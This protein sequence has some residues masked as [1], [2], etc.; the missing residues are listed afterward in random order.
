MA[1]GNMK[2]NLDDALVEPFLSALD[3][4]AERLIASAQSR[5][6]KEAVRAFIEKRDPKFTGT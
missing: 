5:D 2:D 6:H 4:E 1:L 3:G